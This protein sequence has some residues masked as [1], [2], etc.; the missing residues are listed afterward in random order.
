MKRVTWLMP[1]FILLFIAFTLLFPAE[2][3]AVAKFDYS[4]LSRGEWGDYS[5]RNGDQ[6][7]R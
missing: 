6:H 2:I 3:N 5:Y 1:V 7:R 4:D